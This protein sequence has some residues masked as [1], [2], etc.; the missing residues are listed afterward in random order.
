ML[1]NN[2]GLNSNNL[3]SNQVKNTAEASGNAAKATTNTDTD[4]VKL[5]ADAQQ[6]ASLETAVTNASDIDS[7]RVDAIR[8]AIESGSYS[9]DAEGIANK[10]LDSD[11]L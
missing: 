8:Q 2:N 11:A 9:I 6:L 1:I 10:L 4:S 5:S 3:N 7:S